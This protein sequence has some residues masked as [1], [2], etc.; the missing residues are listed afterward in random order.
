MTDPCVA[1]R[2]P[3]NHAINL[4]H[5][6]AVSGLTVRRRE[7][8][9]LLLADLRRLHRRA[10]GVSVDWEL[11]APGAQ[12]AKDAGLGALAQRCHPRT[13]RQPKW[14]NAVLKTPSPRILAS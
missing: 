12:A 8:G 14:T 4:A 1:V 3:G 13:P 11:L 7:P 2:R 6:A 10:A 5:H 9:Q